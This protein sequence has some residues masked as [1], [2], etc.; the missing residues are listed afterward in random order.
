MDRQQLSIWADI[1]QVVSGVIATVI[2]VHAFCWWFAG[3]AEPFISRFLEKKI[4]QIQVFLLHRV[5]AP[6]KKL[7][8]FTES[9]FPQILYLHGAITYKPVVFTLNYDDYLSDVLKKI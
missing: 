8:G 7:A 1:W 6:L 5:W 4:P 9:E 2:A 3:K